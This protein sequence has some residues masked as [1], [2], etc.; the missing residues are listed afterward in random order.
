MKSVYLAWKYYRS[1]ANG[2]GWNPQKMT[3]AADGEW[4]EEIVGPTTSTGVH[5]Q[6]APT[7]ASWDVV[8]GTSSL[9]W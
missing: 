6:S 8:L 9:G 5:P 7:R 4:W 2:F 1:R 3:F